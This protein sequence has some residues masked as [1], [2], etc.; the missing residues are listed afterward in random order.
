MNPSMLT[1]T[2]VFSFSLLNWTRK[3]SRLRDVG[4]VVLVTCGIITQLRC[5]F[6]PEIFLIRASGFALDRAEL[7]EVDLRPGSVDAPT[8]PPRPRRRSARR[9]AGDAL[10]VAFD[11]LLEDAA[12]LAAPFRRRGRRRARARACARRAGVGVREPRP[13]RVPAPAR[14]RAPRRGN[15][16]RGGAGLRCRSRRK[17][18]VERA[19]AG[20]AWVGGGR[21][22]PPR[23]IHRALGHLV[24]HL[25]LQLPTD[26]GGRRRHVHRRLVG[27]ERDERIL[28]LHASPGF[29][30]TS[31]TGTSLKSPMSGTLTSASS[32]AASGSSAQPAQ[33]L[34]PTASRLGAC[35]CLRGAA[36]PSTARSASL[37]LTLSADLCDPQLLH[38]PQ[39]DGTSIVALS[40]SSATS[41]SSGFTMSPG[42]T[43]TSMTGTSLKS[44]MSAPGPSRLDGAPRGQC[45]SLDLRGIGL[46]GS[47]PYFL[48]A[49]A[50]FFRLIR[51]VVRER[52]QRGDG[53]MA[54]HLEEPRSFARVAAAE[55]V[56]A[57]HD[58]AA[59]GRNA[60]IWSAKVRM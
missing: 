2:P 36:A 57:E 27:L 16:R 53:D 20:A 52:L 38:H 45:R 5:R 35:G 32:A 15:S 47:M 30:S 17:A 4:V 3:A 25:D 31:I 34:E 13:R 37:R 9:A 51:A 24:A 50:T 58:V 43:S 8:P 56:G 29:T 55:A 11:V 48:I 40:D 21:L 46:S 49:S 18:L 19:A 42:F 59:G 14:P 60:R 1:L 54:V 10:R 28:G 26:A 44:P 22:H 23:A 39:G 7:R 6:A 12:L 33:R 41:G